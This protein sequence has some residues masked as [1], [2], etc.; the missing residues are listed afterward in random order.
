MCVRDGEREGE[1]E[2]DV[3]YEKDLRQCEQSE[4]SGSFRMFYMTL[5]QMLYPRQ[6]FI[7]PFFFLRRES[8]VTGP[9]SV[10]LSAL[11]TP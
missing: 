7:I 5:M 6:R 10:C 11:I 4:S 2:R 3:K 1:G 8:V 9:H